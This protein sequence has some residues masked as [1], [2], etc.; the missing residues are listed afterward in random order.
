[1]TLTTEQ[2]YLIAFLNTDG[3]GR[4][5]LE[6][7]YEHFGSWETVANTSESDLRKISFTG[8]FKDKIGGLIREAMRDMPQIDETRELYDRY[9][10]TV[11]MRSDELFPPMLAQIA[12]AP[13]A[14]F[15]RGNLSALEQT[16]VVTIVGSRNFTQ[17]GKQAAYSL[18]NKLA[19]ASVTVISGLALGID[20]I[21]HRG[22]LDGGGITIGV[23]GS[24]IDDDNIS[25]R[26]NFNLA[27]EICTTGGGCILSEYPI[28]MVAMPFTFP[29]RN[30][31]MAAMAH[32]TLVVEATEKSGTL[33]T[34]KDALEYNRDVFAIPGSV[35]SDQSRG[36]NQLIARG[37][38]IVTCVSDILDE[39]P[40]IERNIDLTPIKSSENTK[41]DKVA[42]PLSRQAQI[43]KIQPKIKKQ[44]KL[45]EIETKI[46]NQLS[47][48]PVQINDI[49]QR[50]KLST[51]EVITT[52]TIM[53][54]AG[55]IHNIGAQNYIKSL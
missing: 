14:I 42:Y 34:A 23:L 25:P 12:D 50:T 28:G 41:K 43:K 32:A 35:F 29:A 49:I 51:T 10:V 39:L 55:H 54:I 2:A 11:I 7:L 5:A 31:I 36:A 15:V 9:N 26:E 24:G 16:P 22:A 33:I 13:I 19:T 48:K 46:Y 17:Y 27:R 4:G 3:L 44:P 20:A 45:N 30:R 38:K 53:E 40:I 47:G 6:K 18:A 21:A 8:K 37:A 1:M 52:I